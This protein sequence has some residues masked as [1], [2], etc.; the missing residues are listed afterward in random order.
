LVLHP[1]GVRGLDEGVSSAVGGADCVEVVL[2]GVGS[3]VKFVY[4]IL[5]KLFFLLRHKLSK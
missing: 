1:I 5:I 2:A 3:F 4:H